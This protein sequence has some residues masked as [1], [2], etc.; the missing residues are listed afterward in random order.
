MEKMLLPGHSLEDRHFQNHTLSPTCF[1]EWWKVGQ[2]ML[3]TY[4][5]F[6]LISICDTRRHCWTELVRHSP[7][8]TEPGHIFVILR[9]GAI[10]GFSYLNPAWS[11][12]LLQVLF[13]YDEYICFENHCLLPSILSWNE[14]TALLFIKVETTP[15][16]NLLL[17][18]ERVVIPQL[19]KDRLAK[20]IWIGVNCNS[21]MQTENTLTSGAW[22]S[23]K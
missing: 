9:E 15:T 5:I 11:E 13:F 7:W 22:D 6:A 10:V 23:E 14:C 20:L 21:S 16:Q 2:V 17:G 3:S 1:T 4:W 8:V 18:L 19:M 12:N